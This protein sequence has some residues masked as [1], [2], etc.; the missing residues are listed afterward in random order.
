VAGMALAIVD[1]SSVPGA[2]DH[3]CD[4]GKH[5]LSAMAGQELVQDVFVE[6]VPNV[7]MSVEQLTAEAQP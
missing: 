5:L 3:P 6:D 7:T 1:P 4:G 2:F